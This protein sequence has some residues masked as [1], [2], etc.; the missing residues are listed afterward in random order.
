[1]N[2]FFNVDSRLLIQLGE[3]LVKDRSVALAELVKNSF[4]ADATEVKIS[5]NNIKKK[6]G[7]IIVED[8]GVGMSASNFHNTWMRIATIDKEINPESRIYKRKK[9]G[10]KGI[11]RFACRRLSKKLIIKSITKN[12]RGENEELVA[13]FNWDSFISGL[14]IDKIPVKIT[15][16]ILDN[17]SVTGTTLILD[18]TN[19]AWNSKDIK[20]LR[21]ELTDLTVPITFKLENQLDAKENEYDLGFDIIF[22]IPEF[23]DNEE[24]L[25]SSFFKNS[26]ARLTGSIDENGIGNY[27]LISQ[28]GD[29]RTLRRQEIFKHIKN[30]NMEV[31]IFSYIKPF[32]RSHEWSKTRAIEI[33]RERGGIRLYADNFRVFGY[34]EKGDDWLRLDYDRARSIGKLDDET[35]RYIED[36]FR[37]GLRLFRNANIFGHVVFKKESNGALEITINR[38]RI[39][40]NEAFE[41]LRRFARLGIDFSTVIYS[42]EVYKRI[43]DQEEKLKSEAE[44]IRRE[45]QEKINKAEEEKK[46]AE[47]AI[48]LA[49]EKKK[50]AEERSKKAEEERRKAEDERI[51]LEN[52]RRLSEEYRRKIEDEKSKEGIDKTEMIEAK[53]ELAISKEK[54]KIREENGAR[55][56]ELERIKEEEEAR[57]NADEEA[58]KEELIRRRK[59]E[60]KANAEE[61]IRKLNDEEM[62]RQEKLY[63]MEFSQLRTLAST[64]TLILVFEHELQTIITDLADIINT[65]HDL[66][67]KYPEAKDFKEEIDS[68]TDRA[69]MIDEF[70]ALLGLSASIES[71]LEKK[72]WILHSI[73][74][75]IFRSF[76]WYS[77]EYDITCVYSSVEDDLR[78][79]KMYRSELSSILHNLISNAFK[80]VR[81]T[82][83]RRVEIKA[84]EDED[85]LNIWVLDSGKGLK[86]D[87]WE[88]V[89][90]PFISF[91]EPDLKFGSGTG[92]GLKIVRDMARSNDGDVRFIKPPDNWKT[93]VEVRLPR[94]EEI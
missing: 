93:C 77:K 86:E 80:Q 94:S 15:T 55:Y 41:E 38:E 17:K 25:D 18:D 62:K 82:E 20:H 70:C 89:F 1:M 57:K 27:T 90:E 69:N 53:L 40:E 58:K 74:E 56:F 47:E 23:P 44:M 68:F 49:L 75:T 16:R 91:S 24:P 8:N 19:E 26:W 48:A 21:R 92:L 36:D 34:G 32:F 13:I 28:T 45:K 83:D 52:E 72:P 50:K 11:G 2:A 67:N 46:K 10:E 12:E 61:E 63:K 79:P 71:R 5:M 43:R 81:G 33:G 60:E 65:T 30:I 3:K 6:G 76:R 78:A 14:D 88:K 87:L 42:N 22:N 59:E 29:I 73:I 64:G 31:S 39:L 37:P 35:D 84:F 54:E 7:T 4:D 9:A 51:R 85:S 66:I